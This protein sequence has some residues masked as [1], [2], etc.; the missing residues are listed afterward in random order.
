LLIKPFPSHVVSPPNIFA[1]TILSDFQLFKQHQFLQFSADRK[2]WFMLLPMLAVSNA[3]YCLGNLS[4]WAS[5]HKQGAR[6]WTLFRSSHFILLLDAWTL[7]EKV[8]INTFWG[9]I[10]GPIRSFIS[11]CAEI[12]VTQW[13]RR[14][15]ISRKIL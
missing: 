10:C 15:K 4:P 3:A 11:C 12:Q 5:W 6:S 2:M 9:H 8:P 7:H 13:N 14:I 1:N